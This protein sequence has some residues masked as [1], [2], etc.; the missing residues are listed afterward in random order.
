MEDTQ[1]DHALITGAFTV[2]EQSGWRGL[3]V[4]AAARAAGV[5]LERARSR[6]TGRLDLLRRFA[7]LADEAALTGLAEDSTPRDRLLGIVMSRIDAL[8]AQRA[9]VVALL[10]HLQRDPVTAAA[11]L[12]PALTSMR[13]MLDGAGIDTGSALGHLRVKA[14]LGVWLVTL[15]AW[16]DDATEDLSPTMA[17]LDRA[18]ERAEQLENMF[19]RT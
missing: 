16:I 2:I 14:M 4:A 6:F 10:R 1:L 7:R 11:L 17:A 3:S 12:G 13:W 15:K 9:G 8:Q 18:L 5:P 19:A